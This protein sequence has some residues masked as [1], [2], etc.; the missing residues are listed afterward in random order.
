MALGFAALIG[1]LATVTRCFVTAFLVAAFLVTAL[2]VTSFLVAASSD[3]LIDGAFELTFE[4]SITAESTTPVS[5]R[6]LTNEFVIF[7]GLVF[8]STLRFATSS[9]F[10]DLVLLAD[11]PIVVVEGVVIFGNR[12]ALEAELA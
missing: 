9:R 7:L 4:E 6:G 3:A 2:L 8:E 5:L 11:A 1:G 12:V 10:G